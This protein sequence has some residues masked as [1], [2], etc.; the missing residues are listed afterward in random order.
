M[1]SP[2]ELAAVNKKVLN[3]VA[4]RFGSFHHP[5]NVQAFFFFLFKFVATFRI[6]NFPSKV[7]GGFLTAANSQ[8]YKKYDFSQRL[9][10]LQVA[11]K[12][13]FGCFASD[14]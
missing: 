10:L 11:G 1:I 7:S 12:I 9:F 2:L 8:H 13:T 4:L 14:L 3:I 6:L 5:Q